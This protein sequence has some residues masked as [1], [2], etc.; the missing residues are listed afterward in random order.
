MIL[1]DRLKL[2]AP[3]DIID[4]I[5]E[6]EFQTIVKDGN[7]T[8]Y[9]Y[10]QDQPFY[11]LIRKDFL[12]N[13]CVIEFTGK[14]LLDRYPELI[15]LNNIRYC[16]EQINRLGICVIDTDRLLQTAN[17]VKCDVTKDIP[18]SQIKEIILQTKQ[19]LSNFDKW[20]VEKYS[21]GICL[22]NKVTTDRYKKRVCI[23]NKEKE[24]SA[25][26]NATFLNAV[27]CK[28]ALLDYFKEKVRFE[29]N[30]GTVL[31]VKHYLQIAE[32]SLNKV[33]A[34]TANPILSIIDEALKKDADMKQQTNFKDYVCSLILADNN[35]DLAELEAKVRAL[36]PKGTVIKRK[37]K[38]YRD[39]L[40]RQ[41]STCMKV[42]IRELVS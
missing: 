33:L 26:S 5:N 32:N 24:L 16:I 2:I 17:V 23:Y 36:S 8:S 28:S 25:Q 3:L 27:R 18:S 37:M 38:P 6:Q 12:H 35:N 21:N 7:I 30:I 14:I 11:L 29:L 39:Y 9:R 13:E 34:S 42:D 40:N 20:E 22:R 31:Q 4:H 41:D 1:F 10:Q 15:N 19:N